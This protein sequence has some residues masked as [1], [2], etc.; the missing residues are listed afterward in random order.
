M[1]DDGLGD[2]GEAP[3]GDPRPHVEVD[4]LVE[5]EVALVVTAELLEQLTPQQAGGAADAE[6]LA[7]GG[8]AGVLSLPRP[9][10]EGAAVGTQRH[11]AAVEAGALGVAHNPRFELKDPRLYAAQ[12]GVGGKRRSQP[13]DAARLER[14]VGVQRQH[15]RRLGASGTEVG[16]GGEADVLG[17]RNVRHTALAQQL[18]A[19]VAG[20]VV[21]DHQLQS[22][23]LVG[24][25]IEAARQ[26][27]GR[28]PAR[29]HHSHG[30][31][32]RHRA[33]SLVVEP[34]WTADIVR[35][36]CRRA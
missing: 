17:Q 11:P 4:V 14:R 15:H 5:G 2:V 27:R 25:G 12:P 19:A 26:Q 21:H 24:E 18:E 8:A 13:F 20:A 22:V 16:G 1:P 31:L 9:F 28:V 32:A 6:D 29:D 34:T 3:A 36:R 23:P 30:R 10:L 35:R 33:A 7:G